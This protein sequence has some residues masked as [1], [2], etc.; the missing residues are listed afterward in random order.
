MLHTTRASAETGRRSV[1]RRAP[2]EGR[3]VSKRPTAL[4][5]APKRRAVAWIPVDFRAPASRQP[6]RTASDRTAYRFV[7]LATESTSKRRRWPRRGG[8]E[9]LPIVYLVAGS[10]LHWRPPFGRR[11]RLGSRRPA[12]SAGS[13]RQNAATLS[14]RVLSLVIENPHGRQ[15]MQRLGP[16]EEPA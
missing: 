6:A 2:A 4:L 15:L 11:A 14:N 7:Q 12:R 9:G 13:S 10:A 5:P 1:S 16:A 8:P 3:A